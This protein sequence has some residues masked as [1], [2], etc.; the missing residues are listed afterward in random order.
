VTDVSIIVVAF[1]VRDEVLACIDSIERHAGELE[2][3]TI[4]VDNAS[5]DGTAEAVAERFP[6][7]RIVRRPVNEGVAAREHGLRLAQGSF[8]MF[9]DSD[10]RLTEGAL[11][12]MVELM[13]TRPDV[14]LVGPK[15][16]YPD[17]E[18]QLS[19]RRYPPLL[20][21]VMR[22]PPLRRWLDDSRAV[23]HHLMADDPHDR[24]RE[25]EYVL[26]AAQLFSA[27][28]HRA[29]GE[30][31]RMFYG[32]DDAEW[33]FRIRRAGYK[34]LYCPEALVVHDYR[35]AT[36]SNPLSRQAWRYL[37]HFV[38]FQWRWRR[39]RRELIREGRDMDTAA[40]R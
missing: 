38:E 11:A 24:V 3:E 27:E 40:A 17:G 34:V 12:T 31:V 19:T 21:P 39:D 29:A 15:L 9:L 16:V 37:R 25:V 5:T 33:C 13:Q 23:R 14:G 30:F 26:G 18:L 4:L 35:R 7:V 1:D 10:A 36:A 22:R 2:V 8:R 32:H 6:A 20:L 28:A